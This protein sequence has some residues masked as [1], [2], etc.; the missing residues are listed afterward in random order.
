MSSHPL[1]LFK[2]WHLRPSL[3]KGCRHNMVR[4]VFQFCAFPAHCPSLQGK[5]LW[6]DVTA[7]RGGKG[8]SV[9]VRAWWERGAG[10]LFPFHPLVHSEGFAPTGKP[11]THPPTR[12]KGL[13]PLLFSSC[14]RP[15]SLYYFLKNY[16]LLLVASSC[17]LS[18]SQSRY[19]VHYYI[20]A[21]RIAM[22][23]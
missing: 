2:Y 7:G 8:H 21:G 14:H 16:Y 17:R 6:V 9:R 19:F 23:T 22:G 15:M 20:L 1:W 10:A 18:T 13:L 3:I 12:S 5:W 11:P 4:E